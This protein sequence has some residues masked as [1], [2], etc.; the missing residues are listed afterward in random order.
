MPEI[1]ENNEVSARRSLEKAFQLFQAQSELLEQS[2]ARLEV[3]LEAIREKLTGTLESITDAVFIFDPAD[4]SIEEA[5]TSASGLIANLGA[6]VSSLLD[7]E[8]IRRLVCAGIKIDDQQVSFKIDGERFYWMISVTPMK[9]HEART[10]E[11]VS[12]KDITEQKNLEIRL[13][14]E[15]RMAALGKVA[16]SVAHEIRNPLGAIEGFAVLLKRDLKDM[17]QSIPL[18]DKIVYATRQLNSVVGNLLSFTREF[19]PMRSDCDL[20]RII[21]DT[22]CFIHP[23]ADDR[24]VNIITELDKNLMPVKVDS[25][26]IK[27]VFSNIII[28]AV[29]ACPGRGSGRVTIE[30]RQLPGA[31]RISIAD[32]GQGVATE[33][34]KKIFEPFFTM[35]EGGIGLGLA[36]CQRIIDAH[37]GHIEE[38]GI[39]GEGAVFV[40][41]LS[42]R[43]ERE[44]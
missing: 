35:K 32:N 37:M 27:Q 19:V 7:I 9:G 28:N 4:E 23:M 18:A 8:E 1:L 16:A 34:K 21:S 5:N 20:N 14:R 36:L 24:G 12:I 40:I 43:G 26:L 29:E 3:Q 33:K 38:S 41:E 2:H 31:V 17:P 42:M 10:C 15:D 25:V 13:E 30:T 11:V 22:L 6:G 44:T 39:P